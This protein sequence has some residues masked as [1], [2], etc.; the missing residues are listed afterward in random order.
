MKRY[1]RFAALFCAAALF[2]TAGADTVWAKKKKN[3]KYWPVGPEISSAS[4]IIMEADSGTILYEKN[5]HDVHYPASITKIL[6]TLLAIENSEMDEIVTFSYDSVHKTEGSGIAR[7]V[8]E[9]MTMEQCLY[10]VML[11]SSNECAYAVAEHVAGDID[12][13]IQMMNERAAKLGCLNTH[14]NNCNGL[15]DEAHYTS[16]YDMA[17]IAREAYGNETFRIICSTKTYTIP[18]TNKHPDEETYLQNHHQMLYPYRTRKYLYDYCLGGKTGYTTAA[19]NTLVT[20]AEKNG[21]TLICVVL[22]ESS[23]KHYDDTRGLFDFCFDNFKE[24]NIS[25]NETSFAGQNQE[26]KGI[27]NDYEPFVML[28][29]SSNI[30]LPMAAEFTDAVPEIIYKEDDED[31][32]GSICYTYGDRQVGFADITVTNAQ[33]EG[34]SFQEG[35]AGVSDVSQDKEQKEEAEEE[36]EAYRIDIKMIIAIFAGALGIGALLFL[37]WKVIDNFYFIKRKLPFGNRNKSPYKTIKKNK[38]YRKK[39]RKWF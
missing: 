22:N 27:L 12:S 35:D 14:F 8:D 2:I 32:V 5:S 3:T 13:F 33:V 36:K 4:G 9:Q 29:P 34:F 24:M 16:A 31:I 23:G 38:M 11:A 10:G 30:V 18:V 37:I 15:P 19:N 25:E 28:D 39:R 17:L 20:Y 1:I 26:K 7:D 21:M 6:T